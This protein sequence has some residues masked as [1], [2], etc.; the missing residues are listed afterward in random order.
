MAFARMNAGLAP[1]RR[2]KESSKD[3]LVYETYVEAVTALRRVGVATPIVFLSS[4]T[5]EYFTEGRILKSEIAAEFGKVNLVY[6]PNMSAAKHAL[7]L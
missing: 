2:G 6:A 4:N 5:H 7:G 1:A 3:C